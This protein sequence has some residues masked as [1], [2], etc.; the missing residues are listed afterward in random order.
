MRLVV[1]DEQADF[2]AARAERSSR[3]NRSSAMI[4]A[5]LSS[6]HARRKRR[7]SS[8]PAGQIEPLRAGVLIGGPKLAHRH[9]PSSRA[10]DV[11]AFA[12]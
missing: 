8:A 7:V 10:G 1:I 9:R 6:P 5:T 11:F 4:E 12:G 3:A 2:V